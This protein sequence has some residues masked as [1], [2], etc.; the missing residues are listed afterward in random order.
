MRYDLESTLPERAFKKSLFKNAPATLEGG[1]GGGGPTQTTS[2]SNTSNIPEYA[3]PYVETMLGATQKQLYKM[4][5][6]GNITGFQPYKAYGG[7][8]DEQGNQVAYDPSKAIAGFS[9]MQQQA[10]S[11]AANLQVP[12]QFGQGSAMTGMAGLGALN[13]ARQA[14]MYGAMGAQLGASATPQDFQQQVGGYMNPY[15]QQSLNPQLAEIQRQYDITGQGEQSA[16][17]KQ[18]AFGGSRE[19]LMAAENQRNKNMAMNQAIGQGYN[20]AFNA[21]QN[22]YN[23]AGAFQMQGLGMGL[24]GVGAQQAGYGQLGQAASSL[25]NIGNQQLAAQQGILGTQNQIG[26]QQQA[27]QQQVINQAMQDYA[28]AQQYPIMQLGTM[29][30]ML[31]GLPMQ[32]QTTQQYQAQANPITQGIGALGAGASLYNATK[33]AKGGI[34]SYDAGGAIRATLENMS[35]ESLQKQLTTTSSDSV[36]NDIK[37]ILAQ[38]TMAGVKTATAKDGGILSYAEPTEQNNQSL[39]KADGT[40]KYANPQIAADAAM[41]EKAGNYIS[42]IPNRVMNAVNPIGIVQAGKDLIN[43]GQ[44]DTRQQFKENYPELYAAK[45]EE[46]AAKKGMIPATST[47]V[48]PPNLAEQEK[49]YMNAPNVF[50]KKEVEDNTVKDGTVKKENINPNAITAATPNPKVSQNAIDVAKENNP[51]FAEALKGIKSDDPM[52]IYNSIMEKSGMSLEKPKDEYDN[53][54][55]GQIANKLQKEATEFLGP[56]PSIENRK[57]LMAERANAADE[58]KRTQAMRMA[59]FFAMWGSTPGN[60]LVAGLNAMKNKMPDFISDKKEA[61][62]IR[63][64]I[65]KSIADLDQVDYLEKSNRFDEAGKLRNEARKQAMTWGTEILKLTSGVA[66]GVTRE[67]GD[68][69]RNREKIAGGLQEA[70]IRATATLASKGSGSD[71][72][73]FTNLLSKETAV[74]KGLED[75]KRSNKRDYS[76]IGN[77]AILSKSPEGKKMVEDAKARIAAAEKPFKD[78]QKEIEYAKSFNKKYSREETTE[79]PKAR[80]Y[81]P[82]TGK[83][84]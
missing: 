7:T 22:Q 73:M 33:A 63:K 41:Y 84:E 57:R 5:D 45:A 80:T 67:I 37:E 18:G 42:G 38:R 60:T 68:T 9:P 40:G 27:N 3:Q 23:Q 81:N 48:L 75:L 65:D 30:N 78:L 16:A 74:I 4:D 71:D 43:W 58:A 70:Q 53:L 28:N 51:K 66:M 2:T 77:E 39:V 47:T 82:Q 15:I 20:N 1:K 44:T 83:L 54:T 72:K 11:S 24:Q 79:T 49:A 46:N 50:G 61:S 35:N 8:Y 19:A 17:T 69:Q 32:A 55:Q 36:K 12:G 59:E 26:A 62:K 31:R 76:L 56:N 6:S 14:G 25:A 52:A 34:M 13:T 29:S 64:E 10:Q 21:A